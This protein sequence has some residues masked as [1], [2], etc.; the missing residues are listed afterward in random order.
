MTD[1]KRWSFRSFRV[2]GVVAESGRVLAYGKC[3][4]HPGKM[5]PKE[6]LD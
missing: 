6:R 5:L 4:S 3:I 2:D 1:L